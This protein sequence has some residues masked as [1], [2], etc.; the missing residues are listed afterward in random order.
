MLFLHDDDAAYIFDTSGIRSS[1]SAI[2]VF[3]GDTTKDVSLTFVR[4]GRDLTSC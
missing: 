1:P 4:M 3:N 2:I